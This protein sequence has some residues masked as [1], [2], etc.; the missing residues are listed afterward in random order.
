MGAPMAKICATK[1]TMPK[2]VERNLV[3]KRRLLPAYTVL[4]DIAMP[5]LQ[6][7]TMIGT[8]FT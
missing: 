3:G 7:S 1:F 8:N 5:N 2:V 4:K 6:K